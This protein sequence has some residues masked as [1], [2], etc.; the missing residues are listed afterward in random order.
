MGDLMTRTDIPLL[1]ARPAELAVE[2]AI[3]PTRRLRVALVNMPWA[4]VNA[5]SIQCGLLQSIA[6]RAG[7]DCDTH[8]LNI[9]FA[10]FI[11]GLGYEKIAMM[12]AMRDYFLGEWLFSYAAFGEVLPTADYLATYPEVLSDWSEWM[13][14]D[15]DHLIRTRRETLPKWLTDCANRP[16]WTEYDV[17]GFTSTFLQNTAALALGRALKEAHPAAA[18][19]YGGANFDSETVDRD[20]LHQVHS[21]HPFEDHLGIAIERR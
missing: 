13:D 9:E 18:L 4:R 3:P 12:D 16:E 20:H 8:Y 6:R 11:G 21:R 10:A 14:G 7:H 5:P 19:V 17:I 2:P 1:P 15:L